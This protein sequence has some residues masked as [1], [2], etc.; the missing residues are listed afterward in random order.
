MVYSKKELKSRPV[1]SFLS[2]TMLPNDNP[3]KN[4]KFK[5]GPINVQRENNMSFFGFMAKCM[6]DG[7]SSS[8]TGL[9]QK[10][11]KEDSN[12]ITKVGKMIVGDGKKANK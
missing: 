4:G 6:I 11:K 3:T 10:K 12:I 9:A 1:I 5:K 2:N 7:M 8:M